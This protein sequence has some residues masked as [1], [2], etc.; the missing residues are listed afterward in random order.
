MA[1]KG[2]G[3]REGGRRGRV[4]QLKIGEGVVCLRRRAGTGA[5]RMS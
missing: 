5:G 3:V 2:G 4:I 1:G